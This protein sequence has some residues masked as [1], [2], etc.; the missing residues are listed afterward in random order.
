MNP[1]LRTVVTMPDFTLKAVFQNG[2]VRVY[3]VSRLFEEI[4]EFTALPAIPGLFEQASVDPSG[5]AVVWNDELDL[6]SEEIYLNG[7]A[8]S[9]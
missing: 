7:M 1:S 4:P 6:A 3:A 8:V 2:E 9:P 5:R